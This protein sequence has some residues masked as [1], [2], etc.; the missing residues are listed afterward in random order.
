MTDKALL[1]GAEE[2][3][4]EEEE[5]EGDREQDPEEGEWAVPDR[6]PVRQGS[7]YVRNA[8]LLPPTKQGY[9]VTRYSALSVAHPW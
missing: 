1:E 6:A 8:A 4:A 3:Q 5:W 9:P 2:E 7:A